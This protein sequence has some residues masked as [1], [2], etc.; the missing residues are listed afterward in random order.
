MSRRKKIPDI[1]LPEPYEGTFTELARARTTPPNWIIKDLLPVG[2]TGIIAPP[3]SMKSTALMAISLLVAGM[4]TNAIPGHTSANQKGRVLGWSYEATAGELLHTCEHGLGTVVEDDGSIL[5]ADEPFTFQLD[6]PAGIQSLLFWLEELKPK[7]AWLDPFAEFHSL[8]EKDSGQMIQ[9]L[10]PLH[11]WAKDNDSAFVIVHHTRKKQGMDSTHNRAADARGSSGIVGKMDGILVFTPVNESGLIRIEGT[12]KRG[13]SWSKEIQFK[14]YDAVAN[15]VPPLPLGDV[16]QMVLTAVQLGARERD[17]PKT[18]MILKGRA[19]Q[20]VAALEQHQYIM[21]D[22][23][24]ILITK[25]GKAW[26]KEKQ[27]R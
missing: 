5:I 16:E 19:S 14:A 11:K 3:K 2:L 9:L 8:D 12:F 18:L 15:E 23:L 17:L 1:H 26:L 6:D 20:A 13:K 25:K 24:R 22:G 27:G 10:R 7:L 21:R 4:K